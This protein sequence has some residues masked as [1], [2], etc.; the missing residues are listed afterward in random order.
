MHMNEQL[1]PPNT[2][3]PPA[4]A[5]VL[6]LTVMPLRGMP[7]CRCCVFCRC[8]PPPVKPPALFC[9]VTLLA[10]MKALIPDQSPKSCCAYGTT[11]TDPQ[12]SIARRCIGPLQR[13]SIASTNRIK[14]LHCQRKTLLRFACR[15]Q[16]TMYEWPLVVQHAHLPDRRQH[17]AQARTRSSP[18]AHCAAPHPQTPCRWRRRSRRRSCHRRRCL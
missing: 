1:A 8:R 4:K 3:N 15:R 6:F 13:T 16:L 11:M 18:A 14:P 2:A 10:A 5:Q 7:G 9:A 12:W 17:P